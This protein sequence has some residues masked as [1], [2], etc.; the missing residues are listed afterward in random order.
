[1]VNCRCKTGELKKLRDPPLDAVRSR[2]RKNTTKVDGAEK[3]GPLFGAASD[4]ITP[5]ATVQR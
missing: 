4:L 3:R 1:M 5:R 2:A